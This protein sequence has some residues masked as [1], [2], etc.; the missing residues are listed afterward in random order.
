MSN[1]R[2]VIQTD[3]PGANIRISLRGEDSAGQLAVI[4]EVVPAGFDGPPL[5]V[6]PSFDE[7]FY[8]LEGELAFRME[9]E[10]VSGGPG[11]FAFAPRG[12]PHTFA[13]LSGQEARALIVCTPAGFE[14]YFEWLAAQ[15]A[16]NTASVTKPE[17]ETRVVGPQIGA[18]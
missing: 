18:A 12:V 4:E 9:D 2:G 3:A 1:K 7:G 10:I 6:H 14:R 5:H 11:T 8:G 17:S 13:N 16:G 15:Q